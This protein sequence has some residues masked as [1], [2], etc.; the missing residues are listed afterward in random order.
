MDED[1][2]E[3]ERREIEQR[4]HLARLAADTRMLVYR[5]IATFSDPIRFDPAGWERALEKW[6]AAFPPIP[7]RVPLIDK[8]ARH[9]DLVEGADGNQ[10]VRVKEPDH[11]R[12]GREFLDL[13]E[14]VEAQ[15]T[16]RLTRAQLAAKV[17]VLLEEPDSNVTPDPERRIYRWLKERRR[18]EPAGAGPGWVEA[19]VAE[20]DRQERVRELIQR[21]CQLLRGH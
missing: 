7:K 16:G 15:A 8:L 18:W 19:R 9:G 2:G 12:K 1:L 20:M 17:G 10:Y 5:Y 3:A 6:V 14:M 11:L 4:D 13:V 21:I